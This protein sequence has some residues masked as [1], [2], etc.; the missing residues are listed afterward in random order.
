MFP[1]VGLNGNRVARFKLEPV[2]DFPRRLP[3]HFHVA[4][5]AEEDSQLFG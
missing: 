2:D 1:K 4:W 5:G 3:L